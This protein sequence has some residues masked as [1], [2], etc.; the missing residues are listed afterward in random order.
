MPAFVTHILAG[1]D[2]YPM[3]APIAKGA[4]AHNYRAFTWGLLGPDLLFY[5][6][7]VWG[8]SPLKSYGD[9]MHRQK[10]DALFAA[11]SRHV[12][13]RAGF[14]DFETLVSYYAGFLCHYELDKT[15]HP[16][17]Y[18][19]QEKY[20]GITPDRIRGGAHHRAEADISTAM[21]L[22]KIGHSVGSFRVK[23]RFIG[24]RITVEAIAALYH[25]VLAEVYSIS[26]PMSELIACFGD[27]VNTL[28]LLIDSTDVLVRPLATVIDRFRSKEVPLSAYINRTRV[29]YDV[30]NLR[31]QNW[32]RADDPQI[33]SDESFPDIYNRA[34]TQSR[35]SLNRMFQQIYAGQA[36]VP[37]TALSFDTGAPISTQ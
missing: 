24:D 8:G 27:A 36:Y 22:L 26:V 37:D 15:A 17:I 11:I 9:M 2:V 21:Y 20:Q 19:L 4:I 3:L 32:N 7:A 18:H 25:A 33:C 29:D 16:Y 12:L 28:T 13:S 34:V 6:K 5:R 10:T 30:L 1:D 23:Q 35:Q 14:M 31:R